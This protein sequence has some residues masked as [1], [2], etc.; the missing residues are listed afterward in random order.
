MSSLIVVWVAVYAVA[1]LAVAVAAFI[2][3]VRFRGPGVPGPDNM[4]AYALLAGLLWPVSVIGVVEAGILVAI[5]EF[6]RPAVR[7]KSPHGSPARSAGRRSEPPI[8]RP[9]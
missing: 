9:W 4:G 3:A 1:A 5:Q 8:G 7:S 6:H 2:S